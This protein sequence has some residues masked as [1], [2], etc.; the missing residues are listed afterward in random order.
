MIILVFFIAH[1]YLSLFCQS[2]FLHR[3]AAHKQFTM[4]RFWEKFFFILSGIFQGS[5]YLSPY[6]YGVLHRMHHAFADTEKDPHSPQYSTGVFDMM[7]K[8]WLVYAGIKNKTM[9]IEERFKKDVP[10]WDAF[11]RIPDSWVVRLGF[12]VFYFVF[13]LYFATHWWMFLLLP[14]HFLMSPVHGVVINWFAHK[15]GYTNY[16][17]KNTSMNLLPVD[18]LMLG[19]SY[20]N[21]HHSHASDPNFG[22]KWYEIDPIY[23]VIKIFSWFGI[24]QL[25]KVKVDRVF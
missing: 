20:H 14:V 13:Y 15:F 17:V 21:N 12:G 8:T 22:K 10:R 5:S 19:E 9:E 18:V 23:P 7:W 4:S 25:A 6:I 1:W 24:V 16:K 2:F 3:Y 11:D